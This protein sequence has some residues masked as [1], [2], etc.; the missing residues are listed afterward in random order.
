MCAIFGLVSQREIRPAWLAEMSRILRHR[1]PDDEGFALFDGQGHGVYPGGHDTPAK[2]FASETAYAPRGRLGEHSAANWRV[3]L[4]HRR[5]SILDLSAQGHQPMTRDGRCWVVFNGEIFNYLELRD[6]L[7][8]LGCEF[9]TGS[10]TEVLLAA[11]EKWGAD[12]LHRFNGMW[13]FA[14]Y[15]RARA[16]LFL[17]RDRFG[18]KPLYY[19]S[20]SVG[21]AFASEIKAFTALPNWRPRLNRA[22]AWDF[23][24]KGLSEHTDETLFAGVHQIRG[25]ECAQIRLEDLTTSGR[26]P[27]RRWYELKPDTAAGA[28]TFPD[29]AAA[30]R[31]K[32]MDAVRLRLRADVPVG[33]CLSGGID[34]SAIVCCV[35]RLLQAATDVPSQHTFTACSNDTSCDE[36]HFAEAVADGRRIKPCYFYPQPEKLFCVLDRITWHQDEPFNSTSIFAQ[37]SVFEAAAQ[38]AIRVMLD[39]QGSDELFAGYASAWTV[40]FAELL[41]RGQVLQ[42]HREI[43]AAHSNQGLPVAHAWSHACGLLAPGWLRTMFRSV[44][45]TTRARQPEWLVLDEELNSPNGHA[46]GI[47]ASMLDYSLSHIQVVHLPMLLHWEDR[48]SMAY[49]I[50]ARTPFLDYRLVEFA[51]GLAVQH[52]IGD[53]WTKRILRE[54]MTGIL[55]EAIR[56]RRDKKAFALP[57]SPWA[58]QQLGGEFRKRL[59]E[60][61]I[62]SQGLFAPR[63]LE[64]FDRVLAGNEPYTQEYWRVLSFDAWRRLFGVRID[65]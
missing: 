28:L 57:E 27:V 41:G 45:Q 26:L 18:V 59:A 54:S 23:L 50:E 56:T 30:V 46:A 11:Y 49:S 29:A 35:S 62:S 9:H 19:Y 39:G 55:P 12:C 42:C 10:D 64:R 65:S 38:A 4:G 37:W 22:R 25:G 2:V 53:G 14:I 32:L 34:S 17:A 48:N 3:A 58:T 7:R 52:L 15:D 51:L 43:M 24:A 16:E 31:E 13:A 61:V 8:T 40:L 33:S 36:R 47:A 44:W 6:E 1:G 60:A 20:S 63:L 21:I 5:L